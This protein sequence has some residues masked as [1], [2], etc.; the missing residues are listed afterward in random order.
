MYCLKAIYSHVKISY[1]IPIF[2]L[3]NRNLLY[4]FILFLLILMTLDT[5][6]VFAIFT[7]FTIP[8]F[9]DG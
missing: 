4:K 3:Y 9:V 8:E 6:M 2:L 5:S 7:H 1:I